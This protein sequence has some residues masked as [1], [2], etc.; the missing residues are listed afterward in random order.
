MYLL[1]H[2]SVDP[3]HAEDVGRIAH[4][5]AAA[6]RSPVRP[7]YLDHCGPDLASVA[8]AP[9]TV[10]P[11]LFSP[12]YHARFDVAAAVAEAAVPLSVAQPPVLTDAAAW[13]RQLLAEGQG[14]RLPGQAIWVTAGS[15][16]PAVL[17]AWEETA[18]ALDVR[19]AHASGP[20]ARLPSLAAG[21]GAVVLPL[22]VA[23]GYF[24]DVI[25]RQAAGSGLALAPL[26]G[27][28]EA[29]IAELARLAATAPG[30]AA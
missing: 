15:R 27:S 30:A 14:R 22:L 4:R 11:L 24:S 16:D 6:T 13:G 1:A 19:I 21:A 2:G 3:R 23:R 26:A 12:G 18:S 7:C 28:S 17:R 10:V 5:L 20:G 9:G 29:L 8:D 25:A